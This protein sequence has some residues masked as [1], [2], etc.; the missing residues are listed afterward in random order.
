MNNLIILAFMLC[1]G[2]CAVI[3]AGA[4]D[5]IPGVYVDLLPR[6]LRKNKKNLKSYR[7]YKR[8]IKRNIAIL[9]LILFMPAPFWVL[10]TSYFDLNHG[11]KNFWLTVQDYVKTVR[12]ALRA[13]KK[14]LDAVTKI[15]NPLIPKTARDIVEPLYEHT[16]DVANNVMQ[17][18]FVP[19][20]KRGFIG[21]IGSFFTGIFGF[22]GKG[23]GVL[24]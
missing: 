17:K 13:K 16:S 3:I 1:G 12:P 10:S 2:L 9:L 5:L 15:T 20:P 24:L 21:R 18:T 4:L 22:I 11:N 8:H 19:T 7:S 23:V 14:V 6:I